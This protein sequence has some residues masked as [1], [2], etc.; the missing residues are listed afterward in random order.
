MPMEPWWETN[1]ATTLRQ[2]IGMESPELPWTMSF[3]PLP[4]AM[5]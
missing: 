2:E 5:T 3:L 4:R 1:P